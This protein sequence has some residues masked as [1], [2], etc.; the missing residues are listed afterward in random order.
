[1]TGAV[2]VGA[3][4]GGGDGREGGDRSPTTAPAAVDRV[5]QWSRFEA[6][7][8]VVP[9]PANPFDPGAVDVQAVFRAPGGSEVRVPAFW[10]QD[11]RRDLVAGREELE[12]VG[13]PGFRVRFT[14]PRPGRWEW[15]SEVTRAGN[16]TVS[17]RRVLE[18]EPAPSPGFVRVSRADERYLA[19]DDGSPYF[20]VGE[21][22]AW[23]DDRGT[24]AYDEWLA[25]LAEQRVNFIRVWMASWGFGIEWKDTRLGDYTKRLDRAWQLDYVLE[26][27]ARHGIYVELVLLNHGAFSTTFNSE[28]A[29]NPYNRANGGMLAQPGDFFTNAAAQRLFERR[30]RYVVA[31]WGWSRHILAWELWNEVDLTDGY[32]SAAVARWH[33][34]MAGVLRAADPNDHLVSS[35]HAVFANDPTVW[36][37][38][39]LDFTQLHFYSRFGPGPPLFPDLAST[40]VTFTRERLAA[41][42]KPVLFAELGVDSRGPDETRAADPEGVG[43]HL[44][45]WA[46]LV[47]GGFGTAMPWWWDNVIAPDGDRYYPMF[48]AVARFVDGVRFDAEHLAP[49]DVA[50]QAQARPVTAYALRGDATLLVWLKD[51]AFGWESP[52][53]TQIR[54]A[55]V[56]MP[57]SGQWCG[58]WYDTRAG[59]W[60]AE[61]RAAGG[62]RIASPGFSGDVALRARRC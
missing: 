14:P 58:R 22:L 24:F 35:S 25:R 56:R 2:L 55:T 60:R 31:R 27:A 3:C 51:A 17:A 33:R 53:R 42:R 45:L 57:G 16:R 18:V 19:F 46:G 13:T 15:W 8:E 5:Q 41:T 9:A 59:A 6:P 20:A 48:G 43:V 28:W 61:F 7:V 62:A 11:H 49:V 40:V 54:D 12:P 23:Y 52:A 29:E 30:V 32:D 26:A 50:A 38:G 1:V 44:G 34:R 39:A 4:R 37:D 47:S 10:F 36:R 21:N